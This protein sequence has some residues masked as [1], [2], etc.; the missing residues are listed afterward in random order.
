MTHD[1]PDSTSTSSTRRR[2]ASFAWCASEC[3]AERVASRP[4]S[5]E[6]SRARRSF[7]RFLC[8][9]ELPIVAR[10]RCRYLARGGLLPFP[11]RR[12]RH[13][14][15]DHGGRVLRRRRSRA[16]RHAEGALRMA[17]GSAPRAGR[18]LRVDPGTDP[19]RG[20][21]REIRPW[22]G[23]AFGRSPAR[24]RAGPFRRATPWSFRSRDRRRRAGA[25][26]NRTRRLNDEV[27]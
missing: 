4:G 3:T 24:G 25:S 5:L 1:S 18:M 2:A 20:A 17:G 22:S 14:P 9:A 6:R 27:K 10:S 21:R 26:G 13:R 15:G 7:C 11:R 12:Q 19:S 23:D 8:I 16:G